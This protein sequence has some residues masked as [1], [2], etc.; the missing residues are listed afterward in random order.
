MT[1]QR[2]Y[3]FFVLDGRFPRY[4]HVLGVT[5]RLDGPWTTRQMRN[6]LIDLGDRA[7]D[8]WFLVRDWGGQFTESFDATLA[9]AGAAA[10]LGGGPVGCQ[11]SATL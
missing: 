2:L 11:E 10:L 6:L 7:A 1:L 4:P 9:S 5:A 8:F 3:C